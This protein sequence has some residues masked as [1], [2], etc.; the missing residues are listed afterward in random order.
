MLLLFVCQNPFW[1][2]RVASLNIEFDI[3]PPHVLLLI[4]VVFA[5]TLIQL[6]A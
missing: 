3:Q 4:F 6:V 1:S 5:T 2:N